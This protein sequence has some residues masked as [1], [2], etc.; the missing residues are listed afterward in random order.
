MTRGEGEARQL[1][2]QRCR[3]EKSAMFFGAPRL[4]A[5]VGGW[6]LVRGSRAR[7]PTPSFAPNGLRQCAARF[8]DPAGKGGKGGHHADATSA[9][10]WHAPAEFS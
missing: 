5:V 8:G 10:F 1:L 9:A 6:R 7:L 4:L 3:S 2:G